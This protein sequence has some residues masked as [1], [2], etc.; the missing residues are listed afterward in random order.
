MSEKSLRE[1]CPT[2]RGTGQAEPDCEECGGNGW[3][4]DEEDGGTMTCP[5]CRD[6]QCEECEE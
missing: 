4:E 1:D 2:C 5:G 6:A 3:V